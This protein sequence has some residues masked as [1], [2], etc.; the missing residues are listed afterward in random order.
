MHRKQNLSIEIAT[1]KAHTLN[2]LEHIFISII[3][4]VSRAKGNYV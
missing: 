2:L 3:L 4:N 1:E